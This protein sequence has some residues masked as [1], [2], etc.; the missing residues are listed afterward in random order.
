MVVAIEIICPLW[1]VYFC[2]EAV[3]LRIISLFLESHKA[4]WYKVVIGN[5]L[6]GDHVG[7]IL[8]SLPTAFRRMMGRSC[9]HSCLS[10]PPYSER[11]YIVYGLPPPP[12]IQWGP[13]QGWSHPPARGRCCN[14]HLFHPPTSALYILTAHRWM[15]SVNF[16]RLILCYL[17]HGSI[18]GLNYL[19]L[20][21]YVVMISF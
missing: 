18:S 8:V 12:T 5:W 6:R 14:I 15:S 21:C 13:I 16:L 20:W 4:N 1:S 9:F 10:T 19:I 7:W 11:P 3:T 2:L 17:Q